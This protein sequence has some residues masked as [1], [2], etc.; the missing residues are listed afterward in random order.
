MIKDCETLNG[1]T[2]S[3]N[4]VTTKYSLVT[5]L[6]H[7]S[8]LPTPSLANGFVISVSGTRITRKKSQLLRQLSTFEHSMVLVSNGGG[9]MHSFG[10]C[11]FNNYANSRN[12]SATAS[13]H[14]KYS[15]NPKLGVW[16]ATQL[17]NYRVYMEGKPSHMTV[18][19]ILD[20]ES[21]EFE[22]SAKQ[23]GN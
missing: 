14:N 7:K 15:I 23:F 18:D 20:L 21:L 6:C 10:A 2:S 13:S 12:T 1:K 16:V 3:D 8:I 17:S 5:V 22:W 19:R 9:Q 4:Y 11:H